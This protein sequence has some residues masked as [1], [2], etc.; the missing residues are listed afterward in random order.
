MEKGHLTQWQHLNRDT[1]FRHF[2]PSLKRLFLLAAATE[3]LPFRPF[4]ALSPGYAERLSSPGSEA[5]FHSAEGSSRYLLNKAWS[6]PT[7][8]LNWKLSS[9]NSSDQLIPKIPTGWPTSVL[10]TVSS[11]LT[12][13][14]TWASVAPSAAA[15]PFWTLDLG[16]LSVPT[17]IG[18]P[19]P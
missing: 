16:Q 15:T 7:W 4:L 12:G 5:S 2:F 19:Q 1:P 17:F 13:S 11:S 9:F 8:K 6:L 10:P 3:P 18:L 14:F